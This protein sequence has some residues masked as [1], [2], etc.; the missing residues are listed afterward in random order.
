MQT[1]PFE[2]LRHR[3]ILPDEFDELPTV[4]INHL[5]SIYSILT[6]FVLSSF[7][8]WIIWRIGLT[9]F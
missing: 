5:P 4:N 8:W 6:V 3:Q 2:R 1:V 7:L 9:V